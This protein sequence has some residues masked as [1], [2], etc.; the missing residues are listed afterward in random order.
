M[1]MADLVGKQVGEYRL[2]RFLGKGTF[3]EV[4]EGEQIYLKTRVAVKVLDAQLDQ[5][6]FERFVEEARTIAGLEH[7]HIVHVLS[8]SIQQRTPY[9]VMQLAQ[10]SLRDR[11]PPGQSQTVETILPYVRQATEGLQYA[12]DQRIMHLDIKPA[13]LLLTTQN[14]VLLADFGLAMA[15]QTQRTHRTLHGFAGTPAYAAPEQ[16]QNKPSL[17]SDQYAL[18]V[19][20]YQWLTTVL[21]FEGDW[22]AIGHQKVTQN[23]PL[24]R[25]HVPTLSSAVEDVVLRA[26]A[27]DSRARFTCVKEFAEALE[28]ASSSQQVSHPNPQLMTPLVNNPAPVVQPTVLPLP[29]AQA[30]FPAEPAVITK[31]P[32]VCELEVGGRSCSVQAVGRCS[33]C[34]RAFC[35]THQAWSGQTFYMNQ[36]V[37]CLEVQRTKAA[38]WHVKAQ[39]ARAAF[40]ARLCKIDYCGI[41]AISRCH[42]CGRDFCATHRAYQ[43]SVVYFHLCS[44]CLAHSLPKAPPDEVEQ[45][46]DAWGYIEEAQL[47]LRSSEVQSVDIS[48]IEKQ[49]RRIPFIGT[50]RGVDVTIGGRGWILGT[51]P[52]SLSTKHEDCLTALLDLYPDLDR[53]RHQQF[54]RV[55]LVSGGY[56]ALDCFDLHTRVDVWESGSLINRQSSEWR[57]DGVEVQ[58]MDWI[59]AAEAV[60]HLLTSASN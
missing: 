39:A 57:K 38:E 44:Y 9:L 5:A 40:R 37:D 22:W 41:Q 8:F 20:V 16:F 31:G 32:A 13:N 29:P 52:W 23:P 42:D 50:Y 59:K 21:P 19:M 47:R 7:S 28:E 15:L 18:G 26:L 54:V 4:Y 36:C 56:E 60:M 12:H 10:S 55:H 3:G 35:A 27:K 51:L 24:L 34:G 1:M 53:Y 45:D 17:A 25:I 30:Q 43:P 14:Q 2:V 33:T 48:W 58:L 6:G 46:S 49:S 11:F